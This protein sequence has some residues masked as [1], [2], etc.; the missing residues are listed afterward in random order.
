MARLTGPVHGTPGDSTRRTTTAELPVGTR[1]HGIG[2]SV[3]V[4]VK[5]G[6]AIAQYD[7]CKCNG[8]A[9]GYDDVRPTAAISELAIGVADAAFSSGD[10]GFIQVEGV[11]TCKVVAA[12]AAGSLLV[13]S[14][15]AG[16]LKLATEAESLAGARGAAALVT[17]VAAGSAIILS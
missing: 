12:T 4:Y 10:Y 5:A 3:W 15:T 6:A 17:G 2:G 7:A 1:V 13:T 14:A 9:A 16:T 11:C 8:S